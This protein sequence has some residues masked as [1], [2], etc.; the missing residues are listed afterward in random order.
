MRAAF[1]TSPVFDWN[2]TSKARVCVNQGGTSSGKTYAILQV[3][4]LLL[5]EKKRIC[6]VVGQDIPNLKS[7]ALRDLLDR[8]L[9]NV[10]W[11]NSY[12]ESYNKSERIFKFKNGSIL[13][14]SSFADFQDAK[15]GKRDIAFFNE[16]NGVPFAIYEQVAM[17]TTEKI[18]IDYNPSEEFWVHDIV[19]P[20]PNS[21]TFYSNFT[22]NP[23]CPP[24]VI[25][26]L[27]RL[28]ERDA[29]AWK[30]YGLGKTG[31]ISETVFPNVTI[32]DKMPRN[33]KHEGYGMDFGYS[34]D[35]TTLIHCG[36]QNERDIFLDELVY[37]RGMKNSDISEEL[38]NNTHRNSQIVADS[39][40]PKTIDTLWEM[41]HKGIIGASKGGDSIMYGINLLNDYNLHITETSYNLLNERKRYK[42]KVDKKTGKRLNEPIKAWDHGW[43]AARYW[44]MENLHPYTVRRGKRT[45]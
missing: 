37:R 32:I 13:E 31:T 23:F 44:A 25:D 42:F 16:A 26:Y 14:F 43:D 20:D 22:H 34:N 33:L 45:R 11:F 7:G 39:A 29:E 1:S 4:L 24:S 3:I 35:P 28:K 10:P 5:I 40:D 30:V 12:I 36:L 38:E 9:V 19:I 15:N 21:V 18:F 41:G 8:I 6:T 27:K 17:R 2:Y